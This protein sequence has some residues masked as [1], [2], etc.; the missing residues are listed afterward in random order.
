MG[1]RES[2]R[3]GLRAIPFKRSWLHHNLISV[4]FNEQN[5]MNLTFC[6]AALFFHN[7]MWLLLFLSILI[8]ILNPWKMKWN[9]KKNEFLFSCCKVGVEK[10]TL[11][12]TPFLIM[13]KSLISLAFYRR[14]KIISFQYAS[15][16]FERYYSFIM[17]QLDCMMWIIL[18]FNKKSIFLMKWVCK[19][20]IRHFERL[21]LFYQCN[22]K[23]FYFQLF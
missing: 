8:S 15:S 5:E 10:H 17:L 19:K 18:N 16:V 1:V 23:S 21:L 7:N 9:K 22:L 12:R 2:E 14:Q 11:A 13:L 6:C 20:R 3:E 4:K